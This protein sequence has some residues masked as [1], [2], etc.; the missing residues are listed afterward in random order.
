M[1]FHYRNTNDAFRGLVAAIDQGHIPTRRTPSRVGEVLQ[2]EEP[3]AVTYSHPRERVLFNEARD[4]NPFFH[5]FESLWMLVGRNDVGPLLRYNS[6]IADVASDDG[7]TFNGAYGERWWRYYAGGYQ[8]IRVLIDHLRNNPSSRRAVLQMWNV[9][10]D[11]LRID[12]TKDACCNTHV[13][14]SIRCSVNNP[15]PRELRYLDMTVCNR[16]NDL[17]WGMLGAN[18]VHFSFLQEYM[19]TCIGVEVGLYHQ[20]TNNLHVY[21]ERFKPTEWLADLNWRTDYPPSLALVSDPAVFDSEV[22]QFID[23]RDW[24]RRWQE[25]FLDCV[26]APMCWA[27]ELHKRR[28]YERSLDVVGLIASEDWRIA[29]FNWITKRHQSWKGKDGMATSTD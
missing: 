15:D 5:L 17:V 3:V 26:A 18:V 8:Q 13:Y 4:A 23:N 22:V 19:A 7:R 14:F 11:L 27:Y 29:S 16:S 9:E 25:L 2:V 6:K 28:D 1:H 12:T 24:T 10:D 20:F 21:T